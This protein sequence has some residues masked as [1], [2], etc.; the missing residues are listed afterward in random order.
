MTQTPP[1][2]AGHLAALVVVAVLAPGAASAAAPQTP[3]RSVD[4][5]HTEVDFSV[6]HFFTPLRGHFEEHEFDLDDNEERPE[7]STGEARIKVASVNTGNEKRDEHL[8]WSTMAT[9]TPSLVRPRR[10]SRPVCRASS[11]PEI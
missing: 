2:A 6:N 1:R 4:T 9:P 10:S 5:A 11:P 3:G 8:R 7:E